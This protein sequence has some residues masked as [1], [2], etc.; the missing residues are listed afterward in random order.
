MSR[1]APL[2]VS[3]PKL[4]AS[5]KRRSISLSDLSEILDNLKTCRHLR[6]DGQSESMD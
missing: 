6:D 4:E 5:T 1:E 3:N 2:P